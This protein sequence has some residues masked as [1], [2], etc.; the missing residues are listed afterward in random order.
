VSKFKVGDKVRFKDKRYPGTI[1]IVQGDY[2]KANVMRCDYQYQVPDSATISC[3]IDYLE[4]A[5]T[6]L[7]SL[8]WWGSISE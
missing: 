2:L 3:P 5:Q 6:E 4:H 8:S 7:E 1:V